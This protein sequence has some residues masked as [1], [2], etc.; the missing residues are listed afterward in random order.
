[1]C[2]NHTPTPPPSIRRKS[3]FHEISSWSKNVEDR[4]VIPLN[5][6]RKNSER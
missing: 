6:E 2:L 1:M 4:C 3:V 5:V